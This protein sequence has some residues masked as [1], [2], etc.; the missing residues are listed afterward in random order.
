MPDWAGVLEVW[1]WE[2]Y[3][4]EAIFSMQKGPRMHQSMHFEAQK[5]KKN[6]GEGHRTGGTEAK[7]VWFCCLV[8][9]IST[10]H[11]FANGYLFYLFF[12]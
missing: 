7:Y 1:T 9:F 6:S 11:F 3:S 4:A 8:V 12:C 10:S 5:F 2:Y